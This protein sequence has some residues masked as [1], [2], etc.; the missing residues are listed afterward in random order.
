MFVHLS[1][2]PMKQILLGSRL[3]VGRSLQASMFFVLN[4]AQEG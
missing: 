2:V 1:I 4:P 3:H